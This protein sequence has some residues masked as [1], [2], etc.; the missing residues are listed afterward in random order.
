VGTFGIPE[1]GTRF[2][3]Q[4]L[5]ATRPTTLSELV[6]ISG[7]SHGTDVWLNNAQDLIE[8]Q[9]AT[10]REVIC[11]RDDIMGYLISKG[12]EKKTAFKIMENVRKGKGLKPEEVAVMKEHD[13]PEWY[14]DSCQKIKYM[15]PKA[16][17]VAYV[18]MAFRIAFYKVYYPLAFY[19]SFFSVRA[20]DFE[21]QTVLA[22]YDEV[23]KRIKDIDRQ[24]NGASQKDKKL[25]PILEVALEMLA[26]GFKFYPVDIYDS[27]AYKFI[28]KEKGLLLP[29]SALPNVGRTAAQG[30]V[31]ARDEAE[32][33]SVEDFQLRTR[34]N[35]TA[36][37]VLREY[38]CFRDLPASTQLSLFG[39]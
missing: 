29:F 39:G 2:V 13:V 14:I 17:A 27:H 33:V 38:G 22:G 35:K 24:G 28:I 1:F 4:M 7:L 10:L 26:R 6:R 8:S 16:H 37:D 18:T 21:A 12:V 9:T 30:I 31:A 36:M 20:E 34:L 15:F 25:L 11:T 19:A 3:R 23:Y 32:F 5:E